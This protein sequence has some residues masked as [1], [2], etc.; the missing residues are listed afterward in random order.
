MP[1]EQTPPLTAEPAE[2]ATPGPHRLGI[3]VNKVAEGGQW[4]IS[5]KVFAYGADYSGAQL[6]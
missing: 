1:G 3:A 6:R 5:A 2:F 4:R